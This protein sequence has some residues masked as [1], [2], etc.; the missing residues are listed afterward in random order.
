MV[1]L[2][3]IDP[4]GHSDAVDGV[5]HPGDVKSVSD[6]RAKFLLG[7]YG[8]GVFAKADE[9]SK[10]ASEGAPKTSTPRGTINK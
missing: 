8:S 9:A 5:W 6:E 2:V 7:E 3:C 1:R 4:K 10:P